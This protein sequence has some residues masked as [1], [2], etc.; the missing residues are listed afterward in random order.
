MRPKPNN[1]SKGHQGMPEA[2][3]GSIHRN[4]EIQNYFCSLSTPVPKGEFSLHSI[5]S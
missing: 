4:F 3:N 2:L 5:S 1:G